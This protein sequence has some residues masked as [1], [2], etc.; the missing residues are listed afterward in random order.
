[1]S[2]FLL[3]VDPV[4]T[5]RDYKVIENSRNRFST[6]D[7]MATKIEDLGLADVSHHS[8]NPVFEMKDY[9]TSFFYLRNIV[10]KK[11]LPDRTDIC[12]WHCTE[13]FHTQ[14]LGFPLRYVPSFFITTFK[15]DKEDAQASVYR[16]DIHRTLKE[17][18]K[19]DVF[20]R[21]YYETEGIFCSFPCMIA[22]GSTRT[23]KLEY[24]GWR[25]L[26]KRLYQ[27]LYGKELVWRC[28]PDFRLLKKFGGHLTIED[29]RSEEASRYQESLRFEGGLKKDD[30]LKE[31]LMMMPVSRVYTYHHKDT[32]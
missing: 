23:G 17:D 16:T 29:F 19:E 28:A 5:D 22:Y 25:G 6:F 3:K 11:R 14:P 27:S 1:M 21:D 7:P 10:D 18:R 26:V 20:K 24:N 31:P 32:K 15:S 13:Q 4:K 30:V 2:K 8:Q 9:N 12:C